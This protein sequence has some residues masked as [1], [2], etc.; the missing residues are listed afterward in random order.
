MRLKFQ[1][2]ADLDERVLRGLRRAMPEIDFQ[3]AAAAGLERLPDPEVLRLAA[4]AGRVLVTQDRRTMPGHFRRFVSLGR[5]PGVILLREG[6][7]IGSAIEE[8]LLIW[9]ASDAED[10]SN[11]LI[12]IPL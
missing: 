2:D 10:W 8:L 9:S 4:D 3:T 12:W 5:S 11:R 7:S 1:A 6:V